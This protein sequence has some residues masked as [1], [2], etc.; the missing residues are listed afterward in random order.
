MLYLGIDPGQSGGWALIDD[1]GDILECALF[2]DKEQLKWLLWAFGEYHRSQATGI[3]WAALEKV[4]SMPKQGVASTFKFGTNY[5]WWQGVLE[6]HSIP[7]A[8][9]T[10]Q[11]WMKSD[12]LDSGDRSKKHRLEC[13]RRKWPAAPLSRVKD[14]GVA[15][16]LL[17]AEYARIK[18]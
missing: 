1:M 18:S 14:S 8:L 10:P 6:A 7:Y 12:V 9:I 15:D 4:H 2:D 16:A 5:G 13:A 3:Q 11:R 17:L